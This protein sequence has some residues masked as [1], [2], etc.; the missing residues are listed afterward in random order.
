MLMVIPRMKGG[1]CVEPIVADFEDKDRDVRDI[2][3]ISSSTHQ[4]S[5]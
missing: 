2:N 1:P 4:S 3:I 5:C